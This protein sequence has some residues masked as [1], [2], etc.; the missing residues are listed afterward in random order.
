MN[1]SIVQWLLAIHD[2]EETSRL[3]KG[4][5]TKASNFMQL[6]TR[7]EGTVSLAILDNGISNP[8][9]D[10]RDMLEQSSRG[11]IDFYPGIVDARN[12]DPLKH[13]CQLFLIYIVLIET[14]ADRLGI[15]L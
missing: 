11:R 2:L 7:F 5:R 4:C 6:F 8:R 12:H 9:V 10:A 1:K 13:S 14:N 15:D 3:H